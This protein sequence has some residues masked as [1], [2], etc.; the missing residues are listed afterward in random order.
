MFLVLQFKL[1]TVSTY[2][3]NFKLDF[4][5]NGLA[6]LKI[7]RANSALPNWNTTVLPIWLCLSKSLQKKALFNFL[8][9]FTP[10]CKPS[11]FQRISKSDFETVSKVRRRWPFLQY[12]SLTF[13]AFQ[14]HDFCTIDAQGR[15]RMGESKTEKSENRRLSSSAPVFSRP[16]CLLCVWALRS[17]LFCCW[18][19]LRLGKIVASLP[20]NWEEENPP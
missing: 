19:S 8:K 6:N 4:W 5:A 20:V 15:R 1:A 10:I 7:G 14:R 16:V 18:S 3:L 2:S 17:V 12:S 11:Q 13:I 9:I